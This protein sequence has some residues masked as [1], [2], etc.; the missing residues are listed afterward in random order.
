MK[1]EERPGAVYPRRG[2][3]RCRVK[4]TLFHLNRFMKPENS[5][6]RAFIDLAK[7]GRTDWRSVALT[8]LLVKFLSIVIGLMSV[9]AVVSP[10]FSEHGL[11][12]ILNA[13]SVVIRVVN[14]AAYVFGLWLACKKILRRPFL[15]LISTDMTFD[16]R[17]CLLGA[18]LYLLASVLSFVATSLFYSMRA[19]TWL[20]PLGRFE[21]PHHND[22]IVTSIATLIVIPFLAFAEELFFRA[23]LTQT[24]G[25]YIRSTI[26]IVALVAVLFAAAHTQYELQL[27]VAI[28]LSSL[29]LSALTLRDQRLELAIGAHSMMNVWATLLLLFF[30][31]S[32]PHVQVTTTT[33]DL[34]THIILKEVLPFAL[35]YG[36]LQ[37]TRKWFAPSDARLASRSDV[38]PRWL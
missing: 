23:W 27:K 15:S 5:F 19:G 12:H 38:Q 32:R 30:T 36:L 9:I 4:Q 6:S 37:K 14:P 11:F 18:A 3:D 35:M 2:S 16:I 24:L 28:A 25:H 17:R 10:I 26:T 21:W 7:M 33:L 29:G 22:Q 8:F 13:D 1:A 31:G 34:W 20:V